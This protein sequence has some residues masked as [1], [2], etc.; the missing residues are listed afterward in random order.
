MTIAKPEI[1]L[2]Q[3]EERLGDVERQAE[4]ISERLRPLEALAGRG[5]HTDP[6]ES[7]I[8]SA[9]R[10]LDLVRRLDN[11]DAI[12]DGLNRRTAALEALERRGGVG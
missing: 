3:L 12:L 9:G 8:E 1:L 5:M 2:E 6:H 10:L 4:V 7:A 11:I